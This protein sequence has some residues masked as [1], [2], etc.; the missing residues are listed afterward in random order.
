M[1]SSVFLSVSVGF[2]NLIDVRGVKLIGIGELQVKNTGQTKVA[3]GDIYSLTTRTKAAQAFR[4]GKDEDGY[5]LVSIAFTFAGVDEYFT[6]KSDVTATLHTRHTNFL[7]GQRLCTL[8]DPPWIEANNPSTFTA[9][10]NCPTLQPDT[11]Y[12]FVVERTG[13]AAGEIK[14]HGTPSQDVDVLVEG[15]ANPG[16]NIF[17]SSARFDGTTW[18]DRGFYSS[19]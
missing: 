6:A 8:N 16:W 15:V 13:N 1:E 14:I 4:T 7:P 5:T 2:I 9:P 10:A 17:S 18:S 19:T 11:A 3:E 12:V